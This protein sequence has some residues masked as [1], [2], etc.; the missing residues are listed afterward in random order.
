MCLSN[1]FMTSRC[2]IC[3]SFLNMMQVMMRKQRVLLEQPQKSCLTQTILCRFRSPHQSLYFISC[4][5]MGARHWCTSLP[6]SRTMNCDSVTPRVHCSQNEHRLVLPRSPTAGTYI[7]SHQNGRRSPPLRFSFCF[8][9]SLFF[10]TR[11]A[12]VRRPARRLTLTTT[13]CS[14]TTPRIPS[15]L[16]WHF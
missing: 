7:R 4:G 2:V 10:S 3:L 8:G 9:F 6:V 15:S 13:L 14:R 5:M 11:H 16:S 12:T 1:T